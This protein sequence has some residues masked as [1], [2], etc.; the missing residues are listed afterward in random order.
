MDD[1]KTQQSLFVDK[2]SINNWH[3]THHLGELI[4]PDELVEKLTGDLLELHEVVLLAEKNLL[5]EEDPTFPIFI[6]K[7][8]EGLGF[9]TEAEHGG[10]LHG[11]PLF[12]R[13]DDIFGVFHMHPLHPSIVRLV[14]LRM[15]HQI[16]M[17]D[18]QDL[19]IVD[20]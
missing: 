10:P 13:F 4:L 16:K 2:I 5:K 11:D 12:V 3:K 7:V 8:P 17:D 20:P 19:V 14:A 15:A 9:V 1:S 6:A 18:I